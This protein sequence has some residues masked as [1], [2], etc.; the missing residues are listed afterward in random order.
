[1][2]PT[3]PISGLGSVSNRRSGP[4]PVFARFTVRR[5]FWSAR[6]PFQSAIQIVDRIYLSMLAFVLAVK[7]VKADGM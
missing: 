4:L 1:V 3:A 2:A 6:R 5:N 7:A